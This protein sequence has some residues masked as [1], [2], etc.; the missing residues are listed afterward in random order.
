MD[1]SN[2]YGLT[3]QQFNYLH[4][5]FDGEAERF[6]RSNVMES[7]NS[8]SE[9]CSLMQQ[10]FNSLSRQSRV[11]KHLQNLQIGEVLNRKKVKVAEALEELRELITKLAPQGP[12]THCSDEAKVQYLYQAVVGA[13]WEK[14]SLSASQSF[15]HP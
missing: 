11:R 6:F 7:F 8:F 9:A 1:A 3:L 5:L 2:D 12:K 4:H 14:A 13:S 15:N 10:E